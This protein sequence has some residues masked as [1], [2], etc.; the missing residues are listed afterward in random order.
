MEN[1]NQIKP[2]L[3]KMVEIAISKFNNYDDAMNY[4]N[5]N[6]SELFQQANQELYL[7]A[8]KNK[9]DFRQA[10]DD[11]AYLDK[12]NPNY[13]DVRALMD[14]AQFKGT[15]FVHVYTKNE[16]NMVIPVRLQDDL[17]DFSTHGINDKWTVYHNNR[18]NG[19][20]YDFGMIVNFR[21]IKIS[22]EQVKEKQFIKEAC[23]KSTDLVISSLC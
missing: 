8:S 7:L 12:L 15:D 14:E 6:K 5:N 11:L 21:E 23:T 18:Q 16:T 2:I 10:Y 9:M 19:I 1:L 20:N 4:L 3:N 17:L 13:K 22:P